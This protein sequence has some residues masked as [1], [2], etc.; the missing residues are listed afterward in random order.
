MKSRDRLGDQVADRAAP[1]RP[2]GACRVEET[3]ISGIFTISARSPP[4]RRSSAAS[5]SSSTVPGARGDPQPR[6]LEHPLAARA[7]SRAPAA[8]SAPIRNT[9]S[10]SGRCV[11]QQLQGPEACRTA[12]RGSI[13]TSEASSSV[14]VA[15]A[16]A[17]HLQPHLAPR[18]RLDPLVRRLAGRHQ[19]HLVEPELPRRLLGE[20]QV[21]DVRRVERAPEN[22]DRGDRSQPLS[23]ADLA[24]AV[25]DVLERRQLAQADRAAGVQ[26][27]GRVA[28]L[29][30]HPELEAVGEAGRGVDVDAPRRRPRR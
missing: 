5:A 14:V 1:P 25:D 11:G 27:L 19:Q 16:S 28:D 2:A 24:V 29:G 21:P 23:L 30:A 8:T 12:P 22:A 17:R 26:L 10:S 6:Q 18:L 3:P 15:A 4:P 7:S 13:S 20:H 9:S